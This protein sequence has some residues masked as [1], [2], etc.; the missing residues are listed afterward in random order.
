[1]TTVSSRRLLPDLVCNE[2]VNQDKE[3]F[4][5]LLE[6]R[7]VLI[8]ADQD[9][10]SELFYMKDFKIAFL[11]KKGIAFQD[12]FV[13]LAGHAFGSDFE[14]VKPY[15]NQGDWKCDGR[16]VST[17]T[18]FQCYAPESVKDQNT[19]AKIDTDLAGAFKKWPDFIKIWVFVHND[20]HGVSPA[21]AAHLDQKRRDY[22]NLEIEIWSKPDLVRLFDMMP[23]AAKQLMFGVAPTLRTVQLITLSD[24]EPVISALKSQEPDPNEDLPPPPSAQKLEKNSLSDDA[25]EFLRIG[26]R[27]VRLVETYFSRNV[28]VELG[29]K[30]AEAFRRRYAELRSSERPSDEIFFHLQEYA[31]VTGEPKRQVA[32]MAVMAY[33]FDRCDIFEDPDDQVVDT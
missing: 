32:A 5:M 2:S 9:P 22:P 18:I 31:G 26:R 30:I 16:R 25:C 33:F 8:M 13:D 29:E 14:A 17:G 15:G 3:A 11:A 27:K 10:V 21:V 7:L 4:W 24:L 6:D 12:W 28:H 20:P 23:R 19:I 1:M